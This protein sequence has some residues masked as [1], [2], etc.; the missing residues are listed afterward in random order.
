MI[1][2][3]HNRMEPGKKPKMISI[4]RWISIGIFTLAFTATPVHAQDGAALFKANCT[5]CHKDGGGGRLVGPD[6]AGV[7]TKRTEEWLLKWTK[8]STAFIA[9]GDADAKAIFDEFNQITMQDFP[10]LSDADLK[11][12]YAYVATWGASAP[13][14]TPGADTANAAPL[15]DVTTTATPEQIELGRKL[16]EGSIRFMEGGASCISCHNIN[17]KDVIPGGLLAKDLTNAFSRL[18]GTAGLQGILGAPPFPAMTSAYLNK[19][20]NSIEINALMA[21]L[22]HVDKDVANQEQKTGDILRFGGC[23]AAIGLLVLIFGIWFIRKKD[24]VKKEIYNRQLKS[25]TK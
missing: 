17:H 20:L 11:A 3:I 25:T 22:S 5:A 9:S 19:P 16:F 4:G 24:T 13:T 10:N 12:I 18:G 8:S 15:A 23:A 14:P 7:T 21:F 6:L 2:T 1:N